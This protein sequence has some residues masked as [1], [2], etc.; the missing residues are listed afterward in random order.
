MVLFP[1]PKGR[2]P[3]KHD[4]IAS[5]ILFFI[6]VPMAL[7]I[8]MAS[9]VPPATGWISAVVGAVVVGFFSGSSL[10]VTGPSAILAVVV[11]GMVQ[12]FGLP[13]VCVVTIAA[14]VLQIALGLLRIPQYML[15]LSPAVVYG[16]VGGFGVLTALSQLQIMLGGLPSG[17]VLQQI[18]L[19]VKLLGQLHGA[20]AFLGGVTI[21]L[22]FLWSFLPKKWTKWVPS[23]LVAVLLGTLLS[24]FFDV[25]R[26]HLPSNWK[27]FFSFPVW[28]PWSQMREAITDAVMVVLIA[29]S[30]SLISS[31]ATNKLNNQ[32]RR[33]NLNRELIAQGIGNMLSGF[34]GGLP[35]SGAI[36]RTTANIQAGART[37]WSSMLHGVWLVLALILLRPALDWIPKSV[38]AG[39]IVVAGLRLLFATRFRDLYKHKELPVYAATLLGVVVFNMLIGL[40]LGVGMAMGLLIFRLTKVKIDLEQQQGQWHFRIRGALTFVAVPKLAMWFDRIPNGAMVHIALQVDSID[41]AALEALQ[42]FRSRHEKTGGSVDLDLGAIGSQTDK[43]D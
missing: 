28:I 40:L 5:V 24:L 13:L 1:A 37:R 34:L 30:E 36:V 43:S 10:Q 33:S 26:V 29:S 35:M 23:A 3:E 18:R 39:L 6:S 32:P 42:D 12:Q 15:A 7:G 20:S 27:Q 4:W 31:L 25:P 16:L 38:L 21:G 17:N 9:G 19:L 2:W 22:A 14:G 41:H 8:S 11:L